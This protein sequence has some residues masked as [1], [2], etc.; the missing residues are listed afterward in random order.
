MFGCPIEK[1]VTYI[2]HVTLMASVLLYVDAD[3]SVR[4]HAGIHRKFKLNLIEI[5]NI[6]IQKVTE[7][8]S[9]FVVS[10][11]TIGNERGLDTG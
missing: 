9:D 2:Y 5:E 1:V 4:W 6:S 3:L 10:L 7:L 11:Y 8:S